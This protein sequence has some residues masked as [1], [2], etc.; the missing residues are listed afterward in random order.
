MERL[1]TPLILAVTIIFTLGVGY[2]VLKEE[3]QS[4]A[5]IAA[6]SKVLVAA[7]EANDPSAAPPGGRPYVRGVREYFGRIREARFLGAYTARSGSGRSATTD[8][9][10]EIYVRGRRGAGVLQLGFE[11]AKLDAMREVEPGDVHED[12]TEAEEEAVERGFARRGGETANIT[13]LNGAVKL[14]ELP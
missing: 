9:E 5:E 1:K 7:L 6:P 12:L 14:D 11:G 13:V 8:V 4:H 3:A 2:T 10:S